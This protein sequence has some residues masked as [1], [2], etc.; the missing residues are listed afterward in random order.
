[1]A[2]AAKIYGEFF[3]PYDPDE[4]IVLAGDIAQLL[5]SK[6]EPEFDVS[7]MVITKTLLKLYDDADAYSAF[8]EKPMF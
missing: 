1:M 2:E 7:Y 8:P 5:Y 3:A 6:S 4:E